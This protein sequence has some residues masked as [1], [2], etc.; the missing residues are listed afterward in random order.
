M[1]DTTSADTAYLTAAEVSKMINIPVSTVQEWA[2]KRERG[3]D[4]PGPR[5]HRLSNRH[6]RWRRD[7]V[8]KWLDAT[9]V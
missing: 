9:R 3:V 4:A 2:A 6:R 7:D 8:Q 5:H 1:A